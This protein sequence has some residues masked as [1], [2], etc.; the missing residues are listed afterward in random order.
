MNGVRAAKVHREAL[1]SAERTRM[2]WAMPGVEL[3]CP[4][5]G[6][7]VRLRH[8][9]VL[10]RKGQRLARGWCEGC[11]RAWRAI[12]RPGEGWRVCWDVAAGEKV[13]VL[14]GR[15]IGAKER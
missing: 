5:C 1:V 11:K 4:A 3:E 13:Y 14:N 12:E 9:S 10:D 6:G 8:P 7:V 15:E 2:R